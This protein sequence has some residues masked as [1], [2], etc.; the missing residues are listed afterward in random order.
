MSESDVE[1]EGPVLSQ[2]LIAAHD[3]ERRRLSRELHDQLNQHLA[4]LAIELQQLGANPAVSP[5]ALAA[6]LQV[7]WRQTTDISSEVHALSHRLHPTKL[8]ALGFAT[9]ARGHCR[10]ISRQGVAVHFSSDAIGADQI[11]SDVGLCLFRVLE[12]A[13]SNAV[14][15]S[16][17]SQVSVTLE[18]GD[19]DLVL[20]VSDA[21]RGFDAADQRATSGLGLA[22]M[23]L[24]VRAL[25][26]TLNVASSPG[27]GTIIEA[28]LARPASARAAAAALLVDAAR[29]PPVAR[30]A[31]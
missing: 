25:G 7:L 11:P 15:H 17:A 22:S 12:E 20:R 2:R 3:E 21:G 26:G 4:L 19:R 8:E 23:R 18:A 28:R 14:R 10:D 5:D 9:T 6:A 1:P 24:R 29:T 27:G 13:V 30:T 31:G 16:G